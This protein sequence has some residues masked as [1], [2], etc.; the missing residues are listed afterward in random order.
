MKK[1]SK[2]NLT[3]KIKQELAKVNI[4][5]EDDDPSLIMAKIHQMQLEQL[6]HSLQSHMETV[7]NKHAEATTTYLQ[8]FGEAFKTDLTHQKETL[9]NT[10]DGGTRHAVEELVR[11]HEK[12]L[13]DAKKILASS[14]PT[15]T[16]VLPSARDLFFLLS[17][18]L[19][20]LSIVFLA[21]KIL[22]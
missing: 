1:T 17:G 8:N 5:V 12:L 2:D 6:V 4:S 16:T 13:K 20:T 7:F 21:L 3:L 18:S 10:L 15:K 9:L 19:L 22:T 14:N 11:F